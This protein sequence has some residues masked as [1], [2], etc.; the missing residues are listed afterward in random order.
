MQFCVLFFCL[1]TNR[2]SAQDCPSNI[3]FE[4]GS[5]L[6]WTCY[7]GNVAASGNTNVISLVPSG[8]P[9][10]DQHTLY[11][12]ASDANSIDYYGGFPV[13][14]PN[15]SGYSV[16]LGNTSGGAQAEGLSYEFTIPA[17]RNTYSLI[18]HYAVVFQDP[19]H[20]EF[21]QPRLELE[22][23][24]VTD[25]QLITCS[26]FTFFPNGSSLPGFFQSPRG[27][28]TE[29]WCK[30]WSAVTINLNGQAGKT[31][32]LFFKTA[33]CTFRRHFGYA[34]IDVNTEC[35]SEFVGATYCPD[36]TAVTLYAPF[37]Y[38]NYT[39]Y[40][41]TFTQM[42]GTTQTLYYNPP[43]PS[44]TPVAVIVEPYSGYGCLDTLYAILKDTL[45]LQA[46]AG[47]EGVSCNGSEVLIGE[48]PKPG[49]VYNW[50]PPTGL[51]NPGIA[52][53][54]AEPSVT[55]QYIL[56]INSTGGGCRSSDTVIVKASFVDSAMQMLGK[57]NFCAGSSDSAVL[58]V[59]AT[60]NIQWFRNSVTLNGATGISYHISQP[61]GY[62]AVLSNSDGCTTR[63]R[64][65]TFTI[66]NPPRGLRY[67]TVF[68]V[69][70]IE[71]DLHAR[72]FGSSVYWNPS[73]Y[74]S[75]TTIVNPYYKAPEPD[76]EQLYTIDI[77]SAAG[78]LT[79]D[80]QL[81]KTIKE[82][83]VYVPTAFTPN[84]DGRNDLIRPIMTGI[85]QLQAFKI[86]NRGGQL[87]YDMLP[88]QN[89]WDG[90]I[91]GLPQS[92]G[93]YVWLF[94]GLGWDKKIHTQKG[95]LVLIR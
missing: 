28:T 18:Y 75:S 15:G 47:N 3:D 95:T 72:T 61:G 89:G 31:I 63:T 37:G 8:G 40:N 62:Y 67:P 87:V 66:E 70:N 4:N 44:G 64:T 49:V 7:V 68:A 92:S 54:R 74:L 65:E 85:R 33:D 82:V 71:A 50:T 22:V 11:S 51:S 13:L 16:K 24:N 29:V 34:Y 14:C 45:T 21:Q 9:V 59:Q 80:T 10:F 1:A 23:M 81:V 79:V 5:F 19:R 39:W 78:C 90:K 35:S 55:T 88:G 2:S 48:N 36:D 73:V 58:V 94:Q 83:K 53:P 84:H 27:D 38:Q 42:L 56:N 86:F 93:V 69:A 26:S 77:R 46:N 60:Q 25:N 52:N 43:P 76:I 32:R 30:D 91:E 6:N 12:Q 17:N 57:N 20:L 41:N